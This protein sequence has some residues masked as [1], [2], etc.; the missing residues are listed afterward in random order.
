[1]CAQGTVDVEITGGVLVETDVPALPFSQYSF[2]C[3][4]DGRVRGAEP[5][6]TK[7]A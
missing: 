4:F 7:A 2:L 5:Q 6:G 3:K 1:M